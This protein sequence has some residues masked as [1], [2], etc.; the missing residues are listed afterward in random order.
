MQDLLLLSKDTP[1]AIIRNGLAETIVPERIPFYFRYRSDAKKWLESRAIDSHRINSRLL[2]KV[3]RL[4]HKDDM[5][6]VLAVNAATITDNYWVKPFD[7]NALSYSDVRFKI[8]LFDKLALYGSVESFDLPPGRTPELT[9]TGSFEKCWRMENGQWWMY[10]AGKQ[11]ELFSEMLAFRV[12]SMLGFSIAEYEV[13]GDYIKS[14]DFTDNARVDFE[15]AEGIICDEFNYVKIYQLLK[16]IDVEI[17]H[18]YVLMCYYDGLIF[19]MDRHE[20]NFGVIRNS[21][22]GALLSLAPFFDHNIVLIARGY[23]GNEPKDMLITD[24][25]ELMK[26]IDKPIHIRKLDENEVK[27]AALSVPYE[28][29]ITN[30]I[31]A[32]KEFA[33]QYL[34]RREKAL[35]EHCGELIQYLMKGGFNGFR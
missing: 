23:P 15:P 6:A 1:V 24:F 5:T 7:D 33:A 31:S 19:N 10:K 4:E 28:P 2:K 25:V 18:Q 22:S 12:G 16:A 30:E 20:Y 9:N 11:E 26:Y 27:S 3:L 34:L 32:P 14:S 35:K 29:P 13:A 21:D 8:N 17:A